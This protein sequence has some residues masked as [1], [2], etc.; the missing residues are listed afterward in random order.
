MIVKKRNKNEGGWFKAIFPN[1]SGEEIRDIM[2]SKKSQEVYLPSKSNIN[3]N[4][5]RDVSNVK[6]SPE[7]K[8]L[9][10]NVDELL[11]AGLLLIVKDVLKQGYVFNKD[12]E[13]K[14]EELL[15]LKINKNDITILNDLIGKS[16]Y[17]PENLILEITISLYNINN[18]NKIHQTLNDN[19]YLKK[20]IA[21]S[22]EKPSFSK[23]LWKQ[24]VFKLYK[25]IESENN[26]I[27]ISPRAL[28]SANRSS[29]RVGMDILLNDIF[30]KVKK[31]IT[32]EDFLSSLLLLS[33]II[34]NF[35][36]NLKL[37]VFAVSTGYDG[38]I[39]KKIYDKFAEYTS[40]QDGVATFLNVPNYPCSMEKFRLR[41]EEM[42][43]SE[44]NVE[45][46]EYLK[47]IKDL[48]KNDYI[49]TQMKSYSERR[50]TDSL[51][52]LPEKS[53]KLF[54]EIRGDIEICLLNK[55]YLSTVDWIEVKNIWIQKVPKVIE[56]FV[57]IDKEFRDNMIHFNGKKANELMDDS[58]DE[59][60]LILAEKIL[61]INE[62]K[63]R[64]LSV[65]NR[66][67]KSFKGPKV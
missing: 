4:K 3:T 46:E 41:M 33:P 52:E 8:D 34:I 42:V 53:K 14:W 36:E 25:T 31:S 22:F 24:M 50:I 5:Y 54:D 62:E 9:S 63:L 56:K 11:S 67:V 40:Y 59:I 64:K 55:E 23:K 18:L 45:H 16:F 7:K 61:I 32:R 12:Q 15:R 49:E 10:K 2:Y 19:E 30:P 21:E 6:L 60:K 26:R 39:G 51:N 17:I 65:V 44:F 1:L 37:A 13:Q 48:L 66:E 38:T 28:L 20:A 47:N 29:H 43:E 58:L 35:R 57:I 27:S